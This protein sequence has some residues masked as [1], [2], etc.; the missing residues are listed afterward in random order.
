MVNGNTLWYKLLKLA[1]VKFANVL[2]IVLV[3]LL[4]RGISGIPQI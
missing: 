3:L 2:Y 1:L 4:E